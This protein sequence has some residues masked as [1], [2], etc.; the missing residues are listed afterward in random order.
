MD[1]KRIFKLKKILN[2]H[3][4]DAIILINQDEPFKDPNFLY[5]TNTDPT[6][7]FFVYDGGAKKGAKIITSA[8]EAPKIK[9]ESR[10]ETIVPKERLSEFL[11]NYTKGHKR[12]GVTNTFPQFLAEKL[13]KKTDK[14]FVD[15]T[16]ALESIRAIKDTEEIKAIS[17][18][19]TVAAK[20]MDE[21]K[22]FIRAGK[23]ENDV[24]KFIE[25]RILEKNC[26]LSF[27]DTIVN[28]GVNSS[29]PHPLNTNKIIKRGEVVLVDFDVRYKKY[30]TDI[31]RVFFVGKP[32]EKIKK[33]YELIC[34]VF[35]KTCD[36]IKPNMAV[37]DLDKIARK[38]LGADAKYFTYA[39]GHGV[40]LA[41]HEK[42]HISF[43]S[44][45]V[46]KEGMVFSIEPGI[47]FKNF[48]LRIEDT[49]LLT[50]KGINIL[51]K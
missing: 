4:L 45:D 40:G 5:F 47:H 33:K 26:Q 28:A 1:Q 44:K 12:I 41:P 9:K 13:N 48:G 2:E 42:P 21:L 27:M 8:L 32:N 37:A 23:T 6:H 3:K 14:K 35:A 20:I 31:S 30:F 50:K 19:S 7:S 16:E 43:R 18:A 17:F 25:T 29:V 15:V 39:L 24:K 51:T 46:F 36:A 38:A 11:I 22:D 49:V 10:I 34:S